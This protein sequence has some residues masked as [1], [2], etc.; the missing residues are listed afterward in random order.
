MA[1]ISIIIPVLNQSEYIEKCILSVVNQ[2]V[3]VELIVIDGGSTDGTLE[4][5]KKHKDQLAYWV[6][7]P[8]DGQ[9]HAINKGLLK[10]TGQFFNWLN[11]DD[12]L[13]QESLAMVLQL[14]KPPTNVVI[15]QC[16]HLDSLGNQIGIGSAKI[17]NT[18]EGTL[19]NYT[20]GQPSHFYRTEIVQSLGGLNE[21]LHYTMDMELWFRYLL[22]YGH[23]DIETSNLIFS[24]FRELETAKSQHN[25]EEMLLEKHGVLKE[26][27]S[28]VGFA[29][30]VRTFLETI[31]SIKQIKFEPSQKIDADRF[32]AHFA[33][34]LLLKAYERREMK[35]A[36]TLY[37]VVVKG[38]RL[39][40]IEKL[41]WEARFF[42]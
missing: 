11:A 7:E 24:Q 17:W 13:T 4:I 41:F 19:G 21:F 18:L 3:D 23:E 20:M 39:N 9:S 15:G 1:E 32:N 22:K 26:L 31:P 28:V 14:F 37:E 35:K 34:Y 12:Q 25:S 38:D 6:S 27:F 40:R 10:S 29:D 2:Q 8:D 33:W 36:R 30:A 42:A 5:I 16:E